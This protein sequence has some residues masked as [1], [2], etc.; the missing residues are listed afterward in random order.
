MKLLKTEPKQSDVLDG[1]DIVY[2]DGGQGDK[3]YRIVNKVRNNN[4]YSAEYRVYELNPETGESSS[5]IDTI[6]IPVYDIKT[7][8][9]VEVEQYILT[10]EFKDWFLDSLD[11]ALL[12]LVYYSRKDDPTY[13]PDVVTELLNNDNIS[14]EDIHKRL[15][16][17]LDNNCGAY[18]K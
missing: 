4:P 6:H 18:F 17:W 15:D 13:T 8:E 1:D 12:D 5:D 11:C 16:E 14:R 2:L 7:G 10:S 3:Y 9:R